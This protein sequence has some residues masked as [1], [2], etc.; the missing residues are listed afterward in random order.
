M[1]R[2]WRIRLLALALIVSPALATA[3]TSDDQ[4]GRDEPAATPVHDPVDADP[5]A[6]SEFRPILD[7][8][9]HWVEDARYGVVWV[10]AQ[11]WVGDDFA[12][13]LTRGRWALD[14]AGDWVWVSDYPFGDVVFHYGRWVWVVGLGWAW[15]PGYRYAPAWVSWRVPSH[16]ALYV[17]WAPL[18]PSYVWHGGVAVGVGFYVVTPWVFCPSYYV[19]S[20][21]V[22]S[23]HVHDPS[24]MKEAARQ[25]KPYHPQVGARGPSPSAVGVPT[26]RVPARVPARPRPAAPADTLRR[27]SAAPEPAAAEWLHRAGGPSPVF[28]PARPQAATPVFPARERTGVAP[29]PRPSK[30]PLPRTASAAPG[31]GGASTAPRV[32]PR[33]AEGA[34]FGQVPPRHGRAVVVPR[35]TVSPPG[36]TPPRPPLR[37]PVPSRVPASSRVPS[38]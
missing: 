24:R 36:A 33:A 29:Q 1:R 26:S 22:H 2:A 38:R 11:R 10:P 21:H 32:L 34:R 6:L 3:Q 31:G 12:P 5:R 30:P 16:D 27:H 13:Y 28:A 4:A 25:T 18:P 9:G 15:V 14:T 23:H 8:Y 20:P 19:F 35:T 7:K 37:T 17:G